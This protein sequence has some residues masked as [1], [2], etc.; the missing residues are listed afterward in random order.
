MLQ[1][2]HDIQSRMQA[3]QKASPLP[4][5][6]AALIAV[7]KSQGPEKIEALLKA[8]HRLFGENKVQ[9]AE[10]KW[11]AFRN[12][13]PDLELHLIGSL[14]SN[15][16]AD[17][18]ELFDAIETVDRPSLVDALAKA[19][20]KGTTRCREFFVQVNIG[21]ETQKG[22]VLP[23]ELSALLAHCTK[24]G[25]PITGLMCVPPADQNPAPYF[26]LLH[27]LARKH[28]LKQLS[29]GMSSDYETA[30]RL[31]ATHIRVGTAL[32]GERS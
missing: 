19:R 21:E 22:G 11:P 25:L 16:A 7:S 26:A 2:L 5:G 12:T 1:N 28:G 18:L 6:Q 23:A 32:F 14:Q 10:A 9:E 3:A 8:G 4:A 27:T 30:I 31:G 15:K 17:A 24:A 13:F 29:M 20:T